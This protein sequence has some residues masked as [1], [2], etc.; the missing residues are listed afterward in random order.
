MMVF[1]A[2][3]RPVVASVADLVG[4]DDAGKGTVPLSVLPLVPDIGR[5][6]RR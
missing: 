3:G 6:R 2:G 1:C 4:V 5:S